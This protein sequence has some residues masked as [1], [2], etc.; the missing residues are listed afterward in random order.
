MNDTYIFI[1]I[2]HLACT[3][4]SK[5]PTDVFYGLLY[6]IFLF[7]FNFSIGKIMMLLCIAEVLYIYFLV[8]FLYYFFDFILD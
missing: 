5:V 7:F 3:Y 2:I 8:L 4:Y 6:C 1:T